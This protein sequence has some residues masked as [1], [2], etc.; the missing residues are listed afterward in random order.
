MT[1]ENGKTVVSKMGLGNVTR[2]GYEYELDVFFDVINKNHMCTSSKDRTRLFTDQP[3]FVITEQT[4]KDLLNW[5]NS[6]KVDEKFD[7]ESKILSIIRNA[8]S[9]DEL[10]EK[11]TP[12]IKEIQANESIKNIYTEKKQSFTKN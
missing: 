3:E 2:D 9:E 10:K 11:C 5:S 8:S 12:F 4:G 1:Q 6:G 7:A